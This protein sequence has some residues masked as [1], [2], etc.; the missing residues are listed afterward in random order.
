M[1]MT[2]PTSS[3]STVVTKMHRKDMRGNEIVVEPERDEYD[4]PISGAYRI[5][6]TGLSDFFEMTGQYGP[7][8]KT[9]A[10]WEVVSGKRSYIGKK[11]TTLVTVP[12]KITPG[13]NLGKYQMALTGQDIGEGNIELMDLVNLEMDCMLKQETKSTPNG[14]R[15]YTNIVSDSVMPVSDDDDDEESAPPPKAKKKNPFQLDEDDD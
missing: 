14:L 6:L 12:A 10:E 9:R 1:S 3:Q 15:T 7:Q 13:T 5:R 8:T 4:T 2:V 11:F